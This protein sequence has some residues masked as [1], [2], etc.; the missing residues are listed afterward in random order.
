MNHKK[1]PCHAEL[2]AEGKKRLA[3]MTKALA[4]FKAANR[5]TERAAAVD[6][7]VA[8]YTLAD[9]Q[10]DALDQEEDN[11]IRKMTD[12]QVRRLGK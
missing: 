11:L 7:A 8:E 9:A 6:Q 1:R 4:K 5:E 10:D 3:R 12:L 2:V